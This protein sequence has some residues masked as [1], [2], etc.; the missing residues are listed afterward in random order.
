MGVAG[1]FQLSCLEVIPSTKAKTSNFILD[2]DDLPKTPCGNFGNVPFLSKYEFVHL[3]VITC[4]A[5]S[6]K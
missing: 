6:A 4:T 1:V 2:T 5:S 3:F